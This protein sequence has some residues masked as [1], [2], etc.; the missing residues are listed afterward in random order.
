[1]DGIMDDDMFT[2]AEGLFPDFLEDPNRIADDFLDFNN[3]DGFSISN[4]LEDGA[5]ENFGSPDSDRSDPST[6]SSLDSGYSM[7]FDTNIGS[8]KAEIV[9]DEFEMMQIKPMETDIIP[10]PPLSTTPTTVIYQQQQEISEPKYVPTKF[11]PIKSESVKARATATSNGPRLQTR[12]IRLSKL[13]F[14][15]SFC[16]GDINLIF[17]S[18]S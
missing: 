5:F 12:G 13:V 16:W 9:G 10:S 17:G 11:I 7:D 6:S 18:L 15:L 1:M 3:D 4:Y 8:V 14:L 2:T